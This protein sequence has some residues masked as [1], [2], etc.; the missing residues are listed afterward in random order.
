MPGAVQIERRG[1]LAILTLDNPDKRNALDPPMLT[2][3]VDAIR[4]LPSD[5]IRAAV[6]TASGTR[7][8]SAGFDIAALPVSAPTDNPMAEV[9]AA[10]ADGDLPIVAALNGLAVGGACELACAC[11]LRVAHPEVTLRMPPVRLGIVYAAQALQ[12]FVALC[13]L[14]HTR[15]LF[16]TAASIE[17]SRALAWGLLD[18]VVPVDAVLPTAL[19]LAEEIAK[20]APLAIRGTRRTLERLLPPLGPTVAAELTR[21]MHQAW[22]SED[23]A[24]ARRAFAE[25]RPPTFHGR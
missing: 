13:G 20:G 8:F 24:E 6:L 18:R 15:E 5:G 23:A 4:Q 3:L 1:S 10:V 16:L 22:E 12:R 14:S 21:L 9:I 11:D 25:K 17:A 19:A 2:A 7:A